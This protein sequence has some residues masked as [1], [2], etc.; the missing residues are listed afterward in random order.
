M[1]YRIP[2]AAAVCCIA[3]PGAAFAAAHASLTASEYD[4]GS[5]G[6][7]TH[8]NHVFTVRNT[9]DSPLRF[10][11]AELTMPGMQARFSPGEIA[12]GAEGK[13][14]LDWATDHVAGVVE[15]AA[16]IRWNDPTQ[17][18]LSVTLKGSV[19]PPIS[20]EPIPAVFLSTYANEPGERV[21]TIRNNQPQ[22]L[23]VRH[24]ET[25]PHETASI[26]TVE[27]G[28]VFSITIRPAPHTAPGKYED[29]LTLTTDAASGSIAIPV[30]LWIKPDLYAN[31]ETI[32]FGTL[33]PDAPALTQSVVLRSRSGTFQVKSLD[34]DVPGVS[35]SST[36]SGKSGAF[37]LVAQVQPHDL[38][39]DALS[40]RILVKTSDPQFPE[41]VIPVTGTV[42]R[43]ASQ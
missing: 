21:L 16:R 41:I 27:T 37:T 17:P 20:I 26:A 13:L 8:V 42:S 32:D 40:G 43:P 24:A 9:G 29:T 30:H 22:P 34:S 2:L 5:T 1:R 35:V 36:P 4:F 14:T 12:P 33:A 38:R 10:L 39:A 11:G 23:A 25:G 6:Q 28:K 18:L 19:V 31:P 7:G 15:G 3:L